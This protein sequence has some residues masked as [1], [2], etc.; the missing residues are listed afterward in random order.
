MCV[1]D[2]DHGGGSFCAQG[3]GSF[4]S[5][6]IASAR[7]NG[8]MTEFIDAHPFAS[9]FGTPTTAFGAPDLELPPVPVLPLPDAA[10]DTA[11]ISSLLSSLDE[12]AVES[13]QSSAQ[14]SSSAHENKL[15]YARLGIASG[16]HTALRA[17][18]GPTASHC[19]RVAL[20]CSSWAAAMGLDEEVR[21]ALE[22][23]ALLHDVG[24][25]GVPD[26]VLLK[27]GRLLPEEVAHMSRHAALTVEI[28]ASCGVPEPVLEIVHYCR[29]WYGS[30]RGRQ[31]RQ[32]DEI[33]LAA[34]MLSIVD[35]FDSMTTDQ[36]YRPGRSRERAIAELYEF[37]GRQFDPELVRQFEALFA[38]DQNRLNQ[39]LAGRWLRRL[40][41]EGSALPWKV[42]VEYAR[43]ETKVDPK[44][45]IFESKLI[46]NMHDGVVFVDSQATIM[47][48][49]T[50]VERLTGVSS[51]AACGRTFLPTLMDMC[52]NREQRITN[53]ECPVT[54]AIT[55]GVQW[56]GR[57]SIMGR[58][59]RHV[60]VDL[61]AIPVRG[62]DGTVH[63]ATLLL[64]DV[65]SETSLEEK[66]QALHAQVAKD[67]MTQV[68]NRAEFD[69]MLN[70][71]VA[72][73][74]ES[75]L[76]CSLIM[77]DIDHFKSIND[78]HGHQAGDE[79]IITFASL[80]K[81][82]CRSGDL[83][84][85][86]GGEEFAILCADCSNVAATRKAESLRKCLSET[87]HSCLGN[88]AITASFGVTE[89]QAGDTPETM[90]RR[91]DRALLQ[92]K[93][94]GRNQ[95]V[96]LGDGMM[97]EKVKKSWWPFTIAPWGGRALVEARLI[98]TVP[99]EVAV[100]KLRGFIADQNAKIIKTDDNELE[101][102]VTG[103]EPD[104]NR[105]LGDRPVT[106][107]I[108]LKLSQ[109]HYERSNAQGFASGTYVE[110]Q[111]E[112]LIRPRRE[113]D[114]RREATVDKARRLLGSLKSY[115]MA[116]EA[117]GHAAEEAAAV[118]AVE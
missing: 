45:A 50:G 61:H 46:D 100:Q 105:R 40:P 17:K 83:V 13:G 32:G 11:V 86:Y 30:G 106:F 65:S 20:G 54:Q 97:E 25:I 64:H 44:I 112:V 60:A 49:N 73:H 107:L 39:E 1:P 84:A 55:T 43:P 70:N 109:N 8:N 57:V 27:P 31:D 94:Q 72:A 88:Q 99:I 47:L 74:Q 6:R 77:S 90:L 29:A 51:Q 96:Q 38:Q 36:L 82:T 58:Q 23:A 71:F 78:T 104:S 68:A 108:H 3:R 48:W 89:L 19:L 34:R 56:L 67:P 42:V 41:E 35:A 53:D 10:P 101:L 69:R 59:G 76:P 103:N 80:L 7:F 115:L 118:A 33:P 28:L 117:D 92:A 18:H 110:T 66:C 52:N 15:V 93:D 98:T 21:D 14:A 22:V 114:R 24:K 5:G 4:T 2:R 111:I 87:P 116:R 26:K 16:L 91:A 113:R 95:V 75:N 85:R 79:A 37:A 62:S 102:A 9:M 81:S 12:A 63:G